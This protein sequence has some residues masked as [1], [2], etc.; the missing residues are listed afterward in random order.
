MIGCR[1][2]EKLRRE[3]TERDGAAFDLRGFHDQVL[4]H[5][6]LPLATLTR[7]VPNWVVTPVWGDVKELTRALITI[8]SFAIVALSVLACD[9][10]QVKLNAG[11]CVSP[12]TAAVEATAP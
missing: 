2:I 5:G 11:D 6:S 7:E 1:T 9:T 4:A 10:Y 3:L 12:S 8:P